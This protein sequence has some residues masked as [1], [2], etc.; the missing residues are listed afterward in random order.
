MTVALVDHGYGPVFS[1]EVRTFLRPE[2]VAVPTEPEPCR[3]AETVG[4]DVHTV[5]VWPGQAP[6]DLID[7][8][9]KVPS[10]A[11]FVEAFGD[12]SS[13]LIFGPA[14]VETGRLSALRAVVASLGPED[15]GPHDASR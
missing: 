11:A 13:V 1:R 15:H 14:D 9:V 10:T 3:L 12:V 5:T 6:E 4:G 8:L 2:G 7:Q